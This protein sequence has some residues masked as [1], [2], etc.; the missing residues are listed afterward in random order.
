MYCFFFSHFTA[1]AAILNSDLRERT[2]ASN[3]PNKMT[4]KLT[5]NWKRIIL[6]SNTDTNK[7]HNI[8]LRI[9]STRAKTS[10]NNIFKRNS[11]QRKNNSKLKS[12]N[13]Q[14]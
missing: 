2:M 12:A 7:F 4:E 13:E 5:M 6:A 10:N 9:N 1:R 3:E 14:K 8:F 11:V